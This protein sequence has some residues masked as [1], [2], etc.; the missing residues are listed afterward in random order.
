MYRK[1]IKWRWNW[2]LLASVMLAMGGNL[3]AQEDFS[4]T[5]V[6]FLRGDFNEVLSRPFRVGFTG[7]LDIREPN[8]EYAKIDVSKSSDLLLKLVDPNLSI[9]RQGVVEVQENPDTFTPPVLFVA[10]ATMLELGDHD[11]AQFLYYLALLR[12][13]SDAEKCGDG[14]ASAAIGSLLEQFGQPFSERTF[15]DLTALARDVER[16]SEWDRTRERQYDPRWIALHGMKAFSESK[17]AFAARAEWSHI[18]ERSRNE[19]LDQFEQIQMVAVKADSNRDDA[20]DLTER[21]K[22]EELMEK[23]DSILYKVRNGVVTYKGNVLSDA[24]ASTFRVLPGTVYAKDD[25][26]VYIFGEKITNADPATFELI[27]GPYSKDA[28]NFYCGNVRMRV[29]NPHQFQVI[30]W[31]EQWQ[32]LARIDWIISRFGVAFSQMHVSDEDPAWVGYAWAHD[33][34][35]VYLGPAIVED[36][37]FRSLKV[38]SASAAED[39]NEEYVYAIRK[40]ELHQNAIAGHQEAIRRNPEDRSALNNLAWIYATCSNADLRNGQK[41]VE[42]ATR[43]CELSN[44]A[45]DAELDTLAAAYAEAGDFD[46]AIHW[47]KKAIEMAQERLSSGPFRGAGL[48]PNEWIKRLELYTRKES[49]IEPAK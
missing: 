24:D 9:K 32:L 8:G 41:A 22:F 36:A 29:Q 11:D 16:A 48:K 40:S 37:D 34:E 33:R 5:H 1:T 39:R 10:A 26:H 6:I 4:N 15:D 27:E 7:N 43:A 23:L 47:Q 17:V 13:I 38:I 31:K 28:V 21:A 18:D 30:Y 45:N 2:G 19:W 14:S 42:L 3:F 12:A 25:S 35:F 46:N 20:L 49:Y 44:W